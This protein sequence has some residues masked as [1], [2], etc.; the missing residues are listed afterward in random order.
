MDGI[1]SNLLNRYD[2]QPYVI[3]LKARFIAYCYITELL[4]ILIAI[5]Y[6]CYANLNN[7]LYGYAL[8]FKVLSVLTSGL[9]LSMLGLAVLIRGHYTIAANLLLVFGMATVW[10]M[11]IIDQTHVVARLDTI[12]L[13]IGLLSMMPIII[14]KRP[15]GMLF[16]AG[17]NILLLYSF[18]F[19]LRDELNLP[20]AS[21]ISYLADNTVTIL[22]V[23]VISYQVF[24]INRRALEKAEH[25]ILVRKKAELAKT[26]T[27]SIKLLRDAASGPKSGGTRH[28]VRGDMGDRNSGRA[29]RNQA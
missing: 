4:A 18:M 9:A 15:F 17:I 24:T 13:A 16:Y 3:R 20:Y 2:D 28:R 11:I 5:I 27:H 23:T 19:L 1:F 29:P 14:Q 26:G 10:S 22:A 7:P 25:D 8:N 12:V 21:L 6:T